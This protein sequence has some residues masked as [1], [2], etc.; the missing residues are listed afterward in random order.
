MNKALLVI[1]SCESRDQ[2][3]RLGEHLLKK[4]LSACTQVISNVDSMFLWPPGKGMIDY[5]SETL[6]LIKTLESK[7]SALEREILRE[8]TYQNPEIIAI[9]LAH[10]TRKY[11]AWM[12]G[13]LT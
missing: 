11:L 10:V 4:K 9:P 13:E 2:A 5:A 8:H 1:V 6:L 3:E 12:V 7:W